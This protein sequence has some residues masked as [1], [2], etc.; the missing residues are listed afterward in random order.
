MPLDR[1]TVSAVLPPRI[2]APCS[3]LP[4]G[5]TSYTFWAT[6]DALRAHSGEPK[7]LCLASSN[8]FAL[9]VTSFARSSTLSSMKSIPVEIAPLVCCKIAFHI[10]KAPP[11]AGQIS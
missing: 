7:V 5:V 3:A 1:P 9:Y 10:K 11:K 4:I 2:T 8:W 6:S